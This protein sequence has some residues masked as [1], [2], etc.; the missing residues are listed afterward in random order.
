MPY[1]RDTV[2]DE[3]FVDGVQDAIYNG[4]IEFGPIAEEFDVEERDIEDWLR[5]HALPET[6]LQVQI[7]NWLERRMDSP[8]DDE[9]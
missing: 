1:T 8:R 6:D 2:T 5:G 7:L 4:G 3:L 9:P